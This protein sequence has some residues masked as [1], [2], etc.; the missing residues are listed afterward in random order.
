MTEPVRI[1]IWS[2]PRNV[3]T[4]LMRAWENREDTAVVDEPFYGY[5]LAATGADHPGRDEIIAATET[6]WRRIIEGLL[7]PPPQPVPIL[8]QKQMA[9]H[10]LPEVDRDWLG[11]VR[12]AF[13]IREP[14]AVLAS[15][16][17]TRGTATLSDTGLPQQLAL[18]EETLR[19]AGTPPPV[20]DAADLLDDPRGL[21]TRLCA[22]LDVGFDE[23]MLSWPPGPRPSDGIWAQYWYHAVETSTGFEPGLQESGPV[24]LPEGLE[25]VAAAAEPYY[26]ALS[27]HRLRS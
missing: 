18:F 24:A 26:A 6:D 3:S 7:G 9:H 25:P 27:A 15:Y 11:R 12:N 5:Y 13:L 1:A 10:L 21:L 19:R 14:R 20:I 2:G 17:R 4:A 16:A 23:R 8:Y 22:A